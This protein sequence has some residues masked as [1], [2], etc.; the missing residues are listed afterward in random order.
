MEMSA[1]F[2]LYR[3]SHPSW[4]GLGPRQGEPALRYNWMRPTATDQGLELGRP[5]SASHFELSN[6][7]TLVN[8]K[9]QQADGQRR[10]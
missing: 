3:A 2:D 9:N 1:G 8:V 4:N 5:T 10:R 7:T 6:L